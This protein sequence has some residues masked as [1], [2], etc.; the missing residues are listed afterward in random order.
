MVVNTSRRSHQRSGFTLVELLVVIGIIAVL[1][2]LLLPALGR[3]RASAQSVA[4]QSNLRQIGLAMT[5]YAQANRDYLPPSYFIDPVDPARSTL[6]HLVIRSF[7]SGRGD[8]SFNTQAETGLDFRCPSARIETAAGSFASHYSVNPRFM[9]IHQ[10]GGF[11]FGTDRI[12]GNTGDWPTFRLSKI[13][14]STQKVL[15]A[16]GAQIPPDDAFRPGEAEASFF[17]VS[18]DWAGNMIWVPWAQLV[19]SDEWMRGSPIRWRGTDG[20]NRNVDGELGRG[21]IRFRHGKDNLANALFADGHVDA[22]R[23]NPSGQTDLRIENIAFD[24]R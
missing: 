1:I 11:G 12:S 4:C 19:L 23:T 9:P 17:G 7:L 20:V 14:P 24:P 2:S 3:A 16:D 13:R 15:V 18:T 8:G 21:Q 10:P 6:W 22:F 5:M